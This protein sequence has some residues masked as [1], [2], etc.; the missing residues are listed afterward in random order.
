MSETITVMISPE[1]QQV[2]ILATTPTR[3]VLKA[4]LGSVRQA[5]PRAAATLL[6]GLAL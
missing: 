4:I 2:R 1:P 3:D 5:H 6:E